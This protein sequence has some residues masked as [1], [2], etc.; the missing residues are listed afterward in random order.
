MGIF[1]ALIQMEGC[2]IDRDS[3]RGRISIWGGRSG[4]LNATSHGGQNDRRGASIIRHDL[5]PIASY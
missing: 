5:D 4:S 3:A 1:L 2:E